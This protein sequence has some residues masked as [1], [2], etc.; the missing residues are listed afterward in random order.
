MEIP[1]GILLVLHNGFAKITVTEALSALP[2][3][4]HS[5][6]REIVEV[7][8]SHLIDL[9]KLYD[10]GYE[11]FALEHRR[12]FANKI[13]PHLTNHPDYK[14]VYFGLA[15]IPLCIDFGHLFHN[16][17]DFLIFHKHHVTKEWYIDLGAT[18]NLNPINITGIPD[19]NQKGIS[20]ALIRL[21]ISHPIN[22]EDTFEILPNAAE[23]D[24]ALENPDEDAITTPNSLVE[25][26]MAV[27][28]AFDQLSNNRSNINRIHLFASIGCGMA[29]TIGTKISPNIHSYIQTYQYSRT[30]DPK[31]TKALLIKSQLRTERKIGETE[32][33]IIDR[34]RLISNEELVNKIH[35]YMDHNENMSR[36]RIWYQGIIPR[37]KPEIMS[38]DFWKDL[39]AL[40]ETSLKNDS[41][42][43]ETK[44]VDG[45]YWSKNKW[46][47]DDGFYLSIHNRIESEGDILQAIRLFLFHEALHYKKHKLNSYTV[48][49]IGSFPK[50]LET[51]DYQA[52]VYAII[53]EYG[54]YAQMIK[55][56]NNTK[57][58]FLNAIKVAT[59]TMWSFDDCGVELEE[60]Q[61]RRLNRY[62][63]WYWQFARI[64]QEGNDLNSIISILE[65]KPV[66]E[67]NGLRTKEENN[68]FFYLLERRKDSPLELAIFHKNE[69]LRN[70]SALNMP[71]ENLVNGVKSMNGEM[72]L[73]VMRSFVSQK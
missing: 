16:H 6:D 56:V 64:E 3:T 70:G 69:L 50:V 38:E 39:P 63:I 33:E 13:A 10:T 54:Y 25:V 55:E 35:K 31:Y 19:I 58:F 59:E 36:N 15:P 5:L 21:G 45:F 1:K 46:V 52:D 66:I 34:L 24:I 73:D 67:I 60:I 42:D 20:N 68:R 37:L 4:F 72:I 71:I 49:E 17:R 51:A 27:K 43:L 47:I 8:Y 28:E 11:Q 30:R 9:S 22:P 65:E 62:M 40:Y 2:S 32:R 18:D 14:T 48:I 29:F 7:S 26:G 23:I 53:N 61:I 44:T 12:I 41:F 57:D